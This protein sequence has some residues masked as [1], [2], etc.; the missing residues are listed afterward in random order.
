LFYL[1]IGNAANEV[2]LDLVEKSKQ[3][4][5]D[6]GF[7]SSF[8]LSSQEFERYALHHQLYLPCQEVCN[9]Y[10]SCR[11]YLVEL[12]KKRNSEKVENH[13]LAK[14]LVFLH[15]VLCDLRVPSLRQPAEGIL[16]DRLTK[17]RLGYSREDV[18]SKTH[19]QLL[20]IMKDN[21]GDRG[22]LYRD[23]YAESE[24]HLRSNMLELFDRL[25][26]H[27]RLPQLPG[28]VLLTAVMISLI[29]IVII[30]Q[31][32]I[33]LPEVLRPTGEESLTLETVKKKLD[34]LAPN[35]LRD[36]ARKWGIIEE[37]VDQ[38][39]FLMDYDGVSEHVGQRV[40]SLFE[41]EKLKI[42]ISSLHDTLVTLN[43]R[44]PQG[45]SI[46]VAPS[47]VRSR[48]LQVG[49]MVT[50]REVGIRCD[51]MFVIGKP[52]DDEEEDEMNL[53]WIG[54]CVNYCNHSS[55]FLVSLKILHPSDYPR[56]LTT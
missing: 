35:Q 49:N 51:G 40:V 28:V 39:A 7:S 11:Y 8:I 56:K 32:E 30:F 24:E 9:I 1:A 4:T 18:S 16:L 31:K 27:L 29:L 36:V 45:Y 3:Y 47:V 38:Y 22:V 15:E 54:Q 13:D 55:S 43:Q 48:T 33:T 46:F 37:D 17:A 21:V 25:K 41:R 2:D 19:Q 50:I 42:S 6:E 44:S 20:N 23:E 14:E 12:K 53:Y 26:K 52:A 10:H 34:N 5:V